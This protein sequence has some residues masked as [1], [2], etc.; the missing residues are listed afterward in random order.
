MSRKFCSCVFRM[1]V[2]A[3]TSFGTECKLQVNRKLPPMSTSDP[4]DPPL[5][6]TAS[7][8]IAAGPRTAAPPKYCFSRTLPL[9]I[10]WTKSQCGACSVAIP[11]TKRRRAIFF[12]AFCSSGGPG[13]VGRW[14]ASPLLSHFSK[15]GSLGACDPDLAMRP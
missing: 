8:R 4:R 3:V 1:F 13:S 2:N 15:N 14:R 12:F 7:L 9:A 10:P 11:Q 5:S 6:S